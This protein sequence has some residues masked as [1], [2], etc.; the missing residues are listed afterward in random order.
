MWT[1][2]QLVLSSREWHSAWW[3]RR[4]WSRGSCM[5][6]PSIDR[7]CCTRGTSS[8]RSTVRQWAATPRSS[9]RS[10]KTAVGA[11]HSRSCPATETR[12][13]PH[14]WGG[15]GMPH[16]AESNTPYWLF[17]NVSR[18]IHLTQPQTV[19]LWERYGETVEERAGGSLP[20]CSECQA[21]ENRV[22]KDLLITLYILTRA[23]WPLEP[24]RSLL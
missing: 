15:E 14:R 3:T 11:S 19:M 2:E 22:H 5:A 12:R 24:L 20:G 17:K 16:A 18:H 21:L 4:W 23:L 13:H 8:K 9:R 7:A 6:A 1:P 10:W